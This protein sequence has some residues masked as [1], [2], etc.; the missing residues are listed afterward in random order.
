MPGPADFIQRTV[1][2]LEAGGAAVWIRRGLA[3]LVVLGL[4][5]FYMIHEFRGLA[6]SQAMD[7]AQIGRNIANGEG[8]KT[9]FVRPLAIG[10][11]QRAHK[12]VA[13]RIWYDTYNAPLPPLVD[14][15]ALRPIKSHWKMG[16]QDIVY[17]GD[18]IIAFIAICF[19]LAS[20]AILY[21]I[22]TRLFDDRLAILACA[23]VLLCD[24][25]WQ[26]S[27]TG[28]PQMLMLFLFHCTIYSLVRAVQAQ[29]G[30]GRVG[31][32][33][34]AVG[35]GFGLLALSHALTIWM[36]VVALIFAVFY[37][38]PRGWAA[39]IVLGAFLVL[40][41]PWLARNWYLTGNP[42]GVAIYSFFDGINHPEA[43][44]MRRL[45]VDLQDAGP[46]IFKNK[47]TA[48]VIGQGSRLLEYLG[49]SLVASTFFVSLL[50]LFK[51]RETAIT[52]WLV[53]AMWGGAFL[54]MTV[55]GIN[56]EQNVA[57]NQLH[58]LFIPIMTCYGL[59][60]LL[61][62]WN[63]LNVTARIARI[64]FITGIFL[65]TAL[66]LLFTILLPQTN[67]PGVRWPPYIPP[68]I[69][70]IGD[71]MKPN[72]ITASDIPWA[73]SW[74]ADRRSMWLPESIAIFNDFHDY[75]VVG[76]PL[77]G[78]YLTPVSG[79]Q[80]TLGDILKGEYRDWAPL[81]LRSVDLQ[82]FTLKW[83][84]LLGIEGECVFF[85]DTDRQK[86]AVP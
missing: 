25:L 78:L 21:F 58:I 1:H 85:A 40:Y 8:F 49:W 10:Q 14:A 15:I 82:K 72:E 48:N 51:R 77:N 43:G 64:G 44:H 68:Y 32:W 16:T 19:F 35:V 53:L 28:L 38:K 29:N 2:A 57:A 12:D 24:T 37:F 45:E 17:A 11:L 33:L 74:Y 7:Q 71:W 18:K 70:V 20:V 83:A 66:P 76:A 31:L 13:R 52:R 30:G 84:T 46:G 50:H 73:I 9:D 26:Y 69:A 41:T 4:A 36:F 22:A 55:Y 67:R 81:I 47:L 6:T 27:L 79:S 42:G 63:R 86:L 3:L 62:Q 65:I 60:Y 39:L 80:N 54:G 5:V 34:A 59:A 61:V 56:E 23:L 75:G